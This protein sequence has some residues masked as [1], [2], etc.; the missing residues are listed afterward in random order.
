[1]DLDLA[2]RTDPPVDITES[3]TIEKIDLMEKWERSNRMCMM[4]IRK[5]ILEAFKGS[6]SPDIHTAT[7]TLAEVKARFAE[8]EKA[9]I[10]TI[11]AK[12]TSKKYQGKENVKE[13]IM[14]MS[15]LAARLRALKVDLSEELLVHLVFNSLPAQ[16]G[17]FKISY[18]CQRRLGLLMNLS[19][20]VC[21]KRKD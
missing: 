21:K 7:E 10:G 20:T 13:H 19:H 16:F 15:H 11:M 18:N 6:M 2:L 3:S 9:E 17:H 5:A 14:E 12:L 8:N 4:I 1:M